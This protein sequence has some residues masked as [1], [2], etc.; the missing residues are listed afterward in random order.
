VLPIKKVKLIFILCTKCF[1]EK[2]NNCTHCDEERS[3]LGTWTTGEVSKAIEKGYEIKEIFEVWNFKEKNNHLFKG[4]VKDFMKIKLETSPW[5]NNFKSLNAYITGVKTCL[6]IG[7]D[8][9]NITPKPNEGAVAKI[10]LNFLWGKFRQRQN[11][12]QA[13]YV[14]D[15]KRWYQI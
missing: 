6:A 1:E 13:E 12:T 9:K 5:E 11:M 7:L 3:L 8:P 14:S 10:C 4:H 15:A 2:C